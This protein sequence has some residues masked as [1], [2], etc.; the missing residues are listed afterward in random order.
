MREVIHL[1]KALG[2][3][4]PKYDALREVIREQSEIARRLYDERTERGLT[5]EQVA[6]LVGTTPGVI[7]RM[8]D[9][10]YNLA[11]S[12]MILQRFIDAPASKPPSAL[13]PVA[14]GVGG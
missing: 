8:E 4:D 2:L 12:R 9:G 10:D 1:R 7:S 6:K 3:D 14:S 5:Q 11:R 13:A